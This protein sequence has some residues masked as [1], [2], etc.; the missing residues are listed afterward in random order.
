MLFN[1]R[2][3]F[4]ANELGPNNPSYNRSVGISYTFGP[5]TGN[6]W[7][8]QTDI[9]FVQNVQFS[10]VLRNL[11][12]DAAHPEAAGPGHWNDP[13]YL[14]PQ[15]GMTETESQTQFTMWS[16]VAAPL[17]IGSDVRSISPATLAMLTN[18]D[19]IAIDQDRLGVQGTAIS[20]TGN[21]MV[22]AKPLAGGDKAVAL[23]NRGSTPMV[24]S[25]DANA[26]GL[27]P[28]G[29]FQLDNLWQ[30][31]NTETAGKIAAVVPPHGAVLYRVSVARGQDAAAPS[32]VL[33]PPSSPA[34]YPGSQMRLAVPG[35]PFTVTSS[36]ENNGRTPI[37]QV[38][39]TLT[40]PSGWQV[41]PQPTIEAGT[42][43]RDAPLSPPGR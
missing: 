2:N 32:V 10:D 27:P 30:H 35:R 43:P 41:Q 31:S 4:Y 9:G 33:A 29:R 28:A 25:T 12:S 24:V 1:I 3:P 39:L 20:T 15:L 22:W 8:T 11:D 38:R 21:A 37:Q 7:R 17:I 42:I 34:A 23:L 19:V 18:Q 26:V 5:T 14:A 16:M 6:S 13:D 36:I 40:A